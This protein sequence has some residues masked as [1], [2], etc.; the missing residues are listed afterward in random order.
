M[1]TADRSAYRQSLSRSAAWIGGIGTIGGFLS[2]IVMPLGDLAPWMAVG[3]LLLAVVAA[4]GFV[5]KWRQQGMAA[6]GSRVA[7]LLIVAAGST[8]AF[9][10]WSVAL[11]CA[12]ENGFLSERL[13]TV[14]A[15]Q[16]H[17]FS[18]QEDVASIREDTDVI[19]GTTQ[20]VKADTS[21][22]RESVGAIV[23]AFA[24]LAKSG[25]LIADPA[26]PAEHYHNAR[27]YELKG[28]F[29]SA[30]RSYNAFLA[31]NLDF[32]DPWLRYLAM[33]KAQDGI[34]GA[35]ET[36]AY[37]A[38]TNSTTSYAAAR[39]LLL[40]RDARIAELQRLTEQTPAFGP[41]PYL[42][43]REFAEAKLGRQDI[44]DKRAE[45]QWLERFRQLH[46][47]GVFLRYVLDKNEA[48]EWLRD[49]DARF[50][51]LGTLSEDVLAVPVS[52]AL[53]LSNAGW[54]AVFELTD[55]HVKE[56][57]YRLDGQGDFHST[58]HMTLRDKETGLPRPELFVPLPELTAGE[59]ALEVKYIDVH[60][61][62]NGPY[63]LTFS[64][65]DETLR[66]AK[67]ILQLTA[68]SWIKFQLDKAYFTQLVVYRGA[69]AE[70]RY[71]IDADT[72]DRSFPLSPGSGVFSRIEP[73]DQTFIDLPPEA[74]VISVQLT[75]KD[76]T[77][78]ELRR[79]SVAG[80]DA[81]G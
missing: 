28:D 35:R 55:L 19:K 12:P 23:D 18:L 56:I 32:I 2:D 34:E 14:R 80:R 74:N 16:T 10:L 67:R 69:L 5:P 71:S 22:I 48:E 31:A 63:T 58:G 30:R 81:A 8:L 57:L 64:T 78:S 20:A 13:E 1:E 77:R 62:M 11:A 76:G 41:L 6:W 60:D 53:Q 38:Q 25:G 33:I 46:E 75:Y 59:H 79:F 43:S 54:G 39:A 47:Q 68:G 65:G 50:A 66:Q 52:V 21:A 44:R 45:K 17:L 51:K 9:G 49:T 40:E 42:L 24:A 70:I 4:V 3:S 29:A 27:L 72:L 26:T 73:G 61:R 15:L 7:S 37:F 36:L